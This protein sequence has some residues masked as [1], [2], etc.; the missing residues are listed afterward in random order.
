MASVTREETECG[1]VEAYPLPKTGDCAEM[2][3]PTSK[4]LLAIEAP[5]KKRKRTKKAKSVANASEPLDIILES[6]PSE[7]QPSAPERT[8]PDGSQE[9]N[10][11]L[12]ASVPHAELGPKM[13]GIRKKRIKDGPIRKADS[14]EIPRRK[15]YRPA[16][17][18]KTYRMNGQG[19]LQCQQDPKDVT[20][21]G[22]VKELPLCREKPIFHEPVGALITDKEQLTAM[23]PNS[24]DRIGSLKGEYTIKIDPSIAPVQQARRKVPIESKEAI[25]AA[26]D[27]MIAG[28]ILE[29]QIE[30]TPWVNNAT[31]PVKLTGEVRP[32][33]DCIP[34][35]KAIIRE[36]HTLPTVEEIAH[37]LAGARYFTKGDAYKAF[38]H[39]HLSKK[40]R[41]LT[42]FGTTTHGRLRYKRMPFGIKMSQDVF[43][44]QMDHILEQCPGMIGI[45]D[46]VIIYGYTWEDHDSNLINFLNVCQMEGL[47]LSSKKLELRRDRVSFF[48][49]I[50]SREGV[51]PD[52]KKIQGI[53]EM[54]VPET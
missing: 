8:E 27:S 23:Y 38:L 25:C 7:S 26:L 44:I 39:V 10:T 12:S 50:Y 6:T 20:R 42:V 46:D 37:E 14:T 53:E 49:A 48:G 21:V 18:A 29:P 22:S 28:D 41:E 40:S 9:Q 36:N 31:Y 52:P 13:K 43:Q 30:P 33:L 47:C 54:T 19:Q 34:L 16:A 2:T 11:V 4:P 5:K 35:N 1:E 15:Y 45:H 17:D 51:H 24:F 32:C 3:K